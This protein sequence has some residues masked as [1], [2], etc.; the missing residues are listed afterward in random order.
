MKKKNIFKIIMI[1]ILIVVILQSITPMVL[2]VSSKVKTNIEN[3]VISITNNAVRNR[4][5]VLENDM[6]DKWSSIYKESNSLNASLKTLLEEENISID[7]M[8]GSKD[9]QQKYLDS[10]FGELVEILQYNTSSGIFLIMANNEDINEKADYSGFFVR[11]SDPQN[12]L[13]SNSDLLMEKGS[14]RLSHK[15]DISLDS[16]WGTDFTFAGQDNRASDDFFYKPYK[17]ALEHNTT[18]I[19]NLGY[20]SRPFILEDNYMDN[21]EMITYSVPLIFN[22]R[23]YGVLGVEVSTAYINKYFQVKDL[24]SELNAGYALAIKTGDDSYDCLAGKGVLYEN[25]TRNSDSI[26]MDE[27][28][29]DQLYKVDDNNNG[30]GNNGIYAVVKSFK[31]YS[32]NVPYDDTEWVLCGLISG[33]SIYGMGNSIYK[34]LIMAT[35]SGVLISIIIVYV[36]VKNITNPLY[37]LVES[38]RGGVDGLNSYKRTNVLEIDELYNVVKNLTDAQQ[39]SQQ[40][41]MEEKERYRIAVENSQDMFFT[42]VKETMMLEVVNSKY[43]DG[44]WDCK[45]YPKFIKAERIHPADRERFYEAINKAVKD[46]NVDFRIKAI[47]TEEYIWINL[48]A[49]IQS[50]EINHVNRMVGCV[51]DI[52]QT[53]LL[54]D[55]QNAM[56]FYDSVTTFYCMNYGMK[57]LQ[58]EYAKR[59]S[60][61]LAL[62]D[63]HRLSFITERYGL[64]FRDILLENLAEN[65]MRVCDRNSLRGCVYIR[66]GIDRFIIWLPNA[67]KEKAL[68]ILRK[69]DSEYASITDNDN[70]ELSINSG[71]ASTDG[72]V[73]LESL[74]DRVKKAL[75]VAKHSET[76]VVSYDE[77][78]VGEEYDNNISLRECDDIS[79]LRQLSLSSIA[80]N[81]FD[82]SGELPVM[83][84]VLAL[85]LKKLY[86]IDDLAITQFDREYLSTVLLYQW[87]KDNIDN[88]NRIVYCTELEY[89]QFMEQSNIYRIHRIDQNNADAK[90]IGEAASHIN[91]VI[92]HMNDAGQYMGSIIY[93]G[94]SQEYVKGDEDSLKELCEISEII[95][96]KINMQ[97]H[98]LSAKAKSDFLARMSHEIRTPMNGII[99]MTQIALKNNVSEEQRVD[100]L[101]KIESSSNY[102]MG[103]LNDILDMSKIESGKMRLV[104]DVFD[105]EEMLESIKTLISNRT[106]ERHIELATDI[107]INNKWLVGDEL[108]INQ[109]LINLLSNAVKYNNEYGHIKL[110]VKQTDAGNGYSDVYFEVKDDGIGI[111]EDK[112]HL[113]FK[114][115]E[116]A[117]DSVDAR[118]KGTGLGLAISTRIIHMMNSTIN[119]ESELGK[120]ST[121]SFTVR[122]K[123][124]SGDN[125][126]K[127][128][129]N[130]NIDFTGKRV[131]IAEDNVLNMEIAVTFLEE[132]GIKTEQAH[133]GKE[134]VEMFAGSEAGY[135]DMILMDVMMPVMDGL[136]A[137]KHI[138][139]CKHK[140][141]KTIPIY[142][143]SA[144]AFDEDVKRSLDSGMNGHISKPVSTEKLKSVFIKEWG[145]NEE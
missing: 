106:E 80:L 29:S 31:L 20:W 102:L 16:A 144:N 82:K 108:R 136:E 62:I 18:D 103:I 75:L 97:R 84:D 79:R 54:E 72:S 100:C 3:N 52:N 28:V 91:G 69:I 81:V 94:L 5:L 66:A 87:K 118:K 27:T 141:S 95:Q 11:D 110:T 67:G 42:Y 10:V 129:D 9:I 21:H 61:T 26:Y 139:K 35:V 112:Q 122:L 116:Q 65:I 4:Q 58:A 56:K 71:I 23:V 40:K 130:E 119:L 86:K 34:N 59:N 2:M 15:K 113:I 25:V 22:G 1:P 78:P 33:E 92:F 70:I 134:A 60:G 104:N 24:D 7:D 47:D 17:A 126:S 90:I 73:K 123:N 96:N 39:L 145:E 50:D 57:I 133:N 109:V 105:I 115:F 128:S 43:V 74:M 76:D 77:L 45:K 8:L 143:M 111:A 137:V 101:K 53:K 30:N 120:G 83:L 51:K 131:L 127:L 36:L 64:V 49:S 114:S 63:V 89:Q 124:S 138:R 135:Y 93:S 41:L 12:K 48:T 132:Y 19:V 38:V 13:E 46:V 99:G 85:R 55:K 44:V 14:K 88:T 125:N 6:V 37:S 117:D 107:D 98:D 32:N 68:G 121:F 142:A 140:D